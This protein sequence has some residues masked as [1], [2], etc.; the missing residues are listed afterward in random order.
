MSLFS[1]RQS[2]DASADHQHFIRKKAIFWHGPSFHSG[3]NR[4]TEMF[5]YLK[6]NYVYRLYLFYCGESNGKDVVLAQR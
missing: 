3:T 5:V 1:R 2:I 4:C 6:S